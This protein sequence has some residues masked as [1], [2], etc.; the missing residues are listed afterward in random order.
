MVELESQPYAN[1]FANL[2]QR[3]ASRWA[4]RAAHFSLGSWAEAQNPVA[5]CRC[6]AVAHSP[7]DRHKSIHSQRAKLATGMR[8]TIKDVAKL[9]GVSTATVSSVMSGRR[10]VSRELSERVI[11]AVE[12]IGYRPNVVAQSL[13]DQ[14]TKTIGVSVPDITNP[15]FNGIVR[16]I[17]AEAF[18]AGYHL[19]LVSNDERSTVER[20]RVENLVAR[21]VDG[22]IVIPTEDDV[23]YADDLR[24]KRVPTVFVDRG[25]P[26][27][28]FDLIG[29]DNYRA[30]YDGT[31]YLNSLGHSRVAAV[32]TST[33]LHNIRQRFA[34]FNAALGDVGIRQEDRVVAAPGLGDVD[35]ARIVL[36]LLRADDPPTAL[37]C[38][39][40]RMALHAVCAV[41][42]IGIRVPEELSILGFDDVEWV[43]AVQPPVST[44]AQPLHELGRRAWTALRTRMDGVDTPVERVSLSCRLIVRGSTAPRHATTA[45]GHRMVV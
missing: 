26:K 29:V 45:G 44:V 34:G 16:A 14:R 42:S 33:D 10:G 2:R 19:L 4:T 20:T 8:P 17:D 30:A 43:T 22:L 15:F 12:A 35:G 7:A 11:R 38:L 24:R 27:L 41:H 37:F 3:S 23:A 39:T 25:S 21:Q 28:P 32:G 6:L 31:R 40:N 13:R 1:R 9:A 5:Q 36:E 18:D